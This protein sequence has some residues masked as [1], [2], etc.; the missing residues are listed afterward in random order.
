MKTLSEIGLSGGV[1]TEFR[2]V[3]VL[4]RIFAKLRAEPANMLFATAARG[5]V[6]CLR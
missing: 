6:T 3:R 5:A 1:Q 4:L 2:R